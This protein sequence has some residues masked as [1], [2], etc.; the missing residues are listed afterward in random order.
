M[1][2]YLCSKAAV[3]YRF[4]IPIFIVFIFLISILFQLTTMTVSAD[5]YHNCRV[6]V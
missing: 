1:K 5:V 4:F 6:S 3:F 2:L